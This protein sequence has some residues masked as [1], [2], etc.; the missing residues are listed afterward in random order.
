MPRPGYE[1]EDHL[2]IVVR[3]TFSGDPISRKCCGIV[4]MLS[5][6]T[7]RTMYACP[8]SHNIIKIYLIIGGCIYDVGLIDV[9]G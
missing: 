6:R 3:I 8:F 7:Q 1:M 4:V 2:H 5:T 9:E